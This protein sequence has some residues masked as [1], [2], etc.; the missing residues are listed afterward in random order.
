MERIFIHLSVDRH[1]GCLIIS[2]IV[3]SAAVNINVLISFQI[4]SVC[5]SK[6]IKTDI[7]IYVL[8]TSLFFKKDK[9]FIF[10]FGFAE[11]LL[12]SGF[13]LVVMNSGCVL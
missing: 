10:V 9:L 1:L 11:S 8:F 2:A 6:I 7:N 13:S 12:P 5:N 4:T 3:H